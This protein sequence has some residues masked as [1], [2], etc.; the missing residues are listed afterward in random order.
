MVADWGEIAGPLVL[1][2][3]PVSNR[4]AL[5]ALA[6]EA[7]RLGV[8]PGAMIC[9]G[10][11]AAYAG[12]PRA[13]AERVRALGCPVVAGNMEEAL[14][15]GAGDCGCG[16]EEGAACAVM[17]DAWYAHADGE[18]THELRAWMAGLPRHA[19]F[20]HAGRRWA[21]THGGGSAINRF[22]WPVTPAAELEAELA[23]LQAET[24][25]VDGVISGH[26]GIGWVRE[27]AGRV[28]VNAG[29]AG[30]PPNDGD[31]RTEYAVM[32]DG[33]AELRRLA[34]DHAGAAAAMRAAGLAQG[35]E[36][37]LET[38]WWPSEDTLPAQMRRG[39]A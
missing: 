27:V 38:G 3:G 19:A 31:P 12:E 30:L 14:G 15:A 2:G 17:A 1:F 25:A 10:D 34:Y 21:V 33:R 11:L 36:R 37:A 28:W 5:E 9:T 39:A 18:M 7:A 24:G 20:R 26:S 13:C 23:A 6:A 32:E 16:F 35:Y 4:H 22:L 29:S 8:A